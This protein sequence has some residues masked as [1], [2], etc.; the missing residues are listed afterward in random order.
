MSAYRDRAVAIARALV[1]AGLE[2]VPD[3]PQTSMMHVFL[4][5]DAKQFEAAAMTIAR[6]EGLWLFASLMPTPLPTLHKLE[7]NVGDAT[8]E[9]AVDEIAARL[10]SLG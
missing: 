2:L 6:E 1:S 4:R 3:P 8:M 10:A 5:G 9:L 7:L